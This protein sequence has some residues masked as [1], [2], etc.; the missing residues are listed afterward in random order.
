MDEGCM[1]L[2]FRRPAVTTLELGCRRA[3]LDGLLPPPDCA[4]SAHPE[5]LRRSPARQPALDSGNHTVPQITH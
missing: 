4:R 2:D 1:T 3:V 5:T